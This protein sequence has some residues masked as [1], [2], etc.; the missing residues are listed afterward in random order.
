MENTIKNLKTKSKI[1]NISYVL[2]ISFGFFIG[3]A[4]RLIN[5][6]KSSVWHDEGFSI[7]L[8]KLNAVQIWQ[9]SARD[10]HPPLY[11]EL[12]HFW[13]KLFGQNVL[14]IRFLSL[15]A[16]V[17]VVG[18]VFIIVKKIAG[19]RAA[20]I[21]LYL[22]AMAPILIRYSQEA[23][24]YG[25]LSLFML[26]ALYSVIK[27][28]QTPKPIYPYLLYIVAVVC[29]LYTHYFTVLAVISF[30]A[31]FI[32]IGIK[33]KNNRVI[34]AKKWWWANGI[35]VVL[36]L[37]WFSN[38]LAQLSRG[39]GLG[40]LSKTNLYSFSSALW[41]FFSLTDGKQL[42]LI[43]YWLL[44]LVVALCSIYILRKDKS[45]Q[46]YN[47][48]IV[49]YAFL[50]IFVALV[51]SL[52]KPIFH[53]RYFVFSAPAIFMIIAIAI[54]K[55]ATKKTWLL[56]LLT[57]PI[58]F[59]EAVGVRNVY[60]QSNHQI[61]NTVNTLNSEYMLGD[62]IIAGELYVFF[63]ASY[64]NHTGMPIYLYTG[65]VL[66][67]G[68]GE[69][70]LIYDKNIYLNSLQNIPTQSR[71]WLIGKTGDQPY[72]KDLPSN[73]LLIKQVQAGYSELRLYQVK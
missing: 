53:E 54:D 10:V 19:V 44:F 33:Q 60:A 39:Q 24:M 5:I 20:T 14:S 58:L 71:V 66:P 3:L 32:A 48:L 52:F 29:G 69:S 22:C 63:D 43:I 65:R 40:W 46:K 38:M 41:Q 23:R 9:G 50:P 72:Y 70:G 18:L 73:W 11:Y 34:T 67:N 62:K 21:A 15:L 30:W 59:V 6:T 45:E 4:L 56:M 37:P 68:F 31:Y 55:V 61:S 26:L 2:L 47:Y 1:A 57:V 28:S 64:Y 12:L 36:F 13:I 16:S 7:M 25:L 8:S 42:P 35:S 17:F 27:I 51:I 49:I